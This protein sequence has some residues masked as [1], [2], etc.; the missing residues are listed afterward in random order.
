MAERSIT[1]AVTGA[2]GSGKS[3]LAQL[4]TTELRRY[5]ATV[6]NYDED[7]ERRDLQLEHVMQSI[8]PELNVTIITAR[9]PT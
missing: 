5:G 9:K 3:A 4:L 7:P 6:R 1:I 2:N 8:G